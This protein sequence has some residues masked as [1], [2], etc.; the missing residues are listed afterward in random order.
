MNGKQKS[1][2][3]RSFMSSM[4]GSS[5]KSLSW[6]LILPVPITIIVCIAAIA[7]MVPKIMADNAK[8]EAV[9]QGQQIAGQFKT[10][11]GYYT[12]NVIKKV[13]KSKVLK[14]SVNHKNEANGVP[15]PATFIHDVSKLLAEKDMNVNLYSGFP[16]PNRKDRKLDEFQTQALGIPDRKPGQSLFAAGHERRQD[17]RP[18]GGCRQDGGEGLCV[19][20]QLESRLAQN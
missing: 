11:R 5:G 9:R 4:K 17:C 19:L 15:L 1:S 6:R 12:R 14:P 2:G 18:C 20:P 13:V 16:W 8:E 10:I 7:L 3:R